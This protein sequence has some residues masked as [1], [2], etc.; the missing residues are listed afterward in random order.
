MVVIN[1]DAMRNCWLLIVFSNVLFAQSDR[2]TITGTVSDQHGAQIP[3]VTITATH[4]N[5]NTQFKTT[6]TVSGEFNLSSLPVGLY[7]VAMQVE[8]FRTSVRDNVTIE[9]GTTVRLDT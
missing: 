7:K 4:K 8:G 9:A 3:G 6:T 5:T 2:S 1:K